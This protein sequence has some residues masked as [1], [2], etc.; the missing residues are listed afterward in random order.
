MTNRRLTWLVFS[1]FA[2]AVFFHYWGWLKAPENL[3]QQALIPFTKTAHHL[4]LGAK[5]FYDRYLSRQDLLEKNQQC[6]NQ[7]NKLAIDKTELEMFR[8][9]NQSLR[10][11][12]N[13][14]KKEKK[15][16]L[17]EIIG[18]SAD[19]LSTSLFINRGS[20]DNIKSGNPVVAE[21]GLLLGKIIRVE[22]N[23]SLVQLITD[24][25]SKIAAAVL[26]QEKTAGVANGEHGISVKMTMIPLN[27]II[28]IGD[29]IVTSGLETNLPRGLII[30]RVETISK[31][32]YAPFQSA[33]LQPLVDFSKV[34][35]AGVLVE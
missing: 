34:T 17:A 12:L 15:L 19:N 35:L 31:E 22:K 23:I 11:L 13:F 2:L 28:K 8:Q 18:K 7:L 33:R 1:I 30:G 26:N 10:A 3:L 16:V 21:E 29:L 25:Q 27:E 4:R 24:N 5:N 20:D 14:A 6:L 9:E 32:L